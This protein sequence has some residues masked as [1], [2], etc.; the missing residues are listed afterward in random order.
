VSDARPIT[1]I[2][3]YICGNCW[4]SFSRS[5]PG[6]TQ[7]D[8]IV[9]PHCGHEQPREGGDLAELV[10]N[11]PVSRDDDAD[12]LESFAAPSAPARQ[13]QVSEGFP[14]IDA[15]LPADLGAAQPAPA[16]VQVPP[17]A[18]V[19]KGEDTDP[20]L[21]VPSPQAF[22]AGDDEIDADASEATPVETRLEDLLAAA[23]S[24]PAVLVRE[25]EPAV[26][27][28]TVSSGDDDLANQLAAAFAAAE[29]GLVAADPASLAAPLP[30]VAT[31]PGSV[32]ETAPADEPE[33]ADVDAVDR[34]WKL[35]A[36]GL[37][38]NFH[39]LEALLT[40]A[41]N[42]TGQVMSVSLTNGDDWKDFYSFY[43]ALSAGEAPELAY[44]GAL[45]PAAAP[46]PQSI[47]VTARMA[48]L[49]T[50]QLKA[51]APELTM[52]ASPTRLPTA[53]MP[54]VAAQAAPEPSSMP[55]PGPGPGP[56]SA[57]SRTAPAPVAVPARQPSRQTSAPPAPAPANSRKPALIGLGVVL[58]LLG[59]VLVLKMLN[60]LK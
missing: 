16:G 43:A 55:E 36:M 54:A 22:V 42:K 32:L 33:V 26:A 34:D 41:A 9:C 48:R 59:A 52:P 57:P 44:A 35:K 13:M 49:S 46:A 1:N 51:V 17:E 39:G 29:G 12:A 11:A 25:A 3:D 23:T 18:G 30:P 14:T 15:W 20:E 50:Q 6:V 27:A 47:H 58:L 7:G 8:R 4:S 24:A 31:D 5:D 53:T 19:A 21:A 2:T 45:E 60:V 38:Y 10:R 28:A 40:W 37:T 56:T